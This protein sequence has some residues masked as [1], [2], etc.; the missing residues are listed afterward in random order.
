MCECGCVSNQKRYRFPAP[1]KGFY[2]LTLIPHCVDCNGPIAVSIELIA[3]SSVIYR[4]VRA[5]DYIAGDLPFEQ[6]PDS[7]GVLVECGRMKHDFVD[8]L[9]RHLAGVDSSEI[10][11]DGVIDD[12]GA[13][14]IL[15]EMYDDAQ[16][17]PRLVV[18]ES[19]VK[20]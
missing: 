17:S 7:K 14:V 19:G 5:G 3:P 18:P 13:E 9:K 6:W 1:G 2:V 20:R 11:E 10:G 16:C 12:A 15:E 4:E 8:V